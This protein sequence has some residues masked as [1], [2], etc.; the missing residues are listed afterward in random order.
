MFELTK[1]HFKTFYSQRLRKDPIVFCQIG[2]HKWQEV[3][4]SPDTVLPGICHAVGH[5]TYGVCMHSLLQLYL[6][7]QW[8][9][10]LLL[11]LSLKIK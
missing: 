6:Q 2:K 1:V 9:Y 7:G 11:A 10:L 4:N 5:L 8:L 3:I